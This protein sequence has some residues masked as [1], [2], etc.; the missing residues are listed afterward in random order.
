MCGPVRM[1]ECVFEEK[2]AECIPVG[3]KEECLYTDIRR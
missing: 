2:H 3:G 1:G